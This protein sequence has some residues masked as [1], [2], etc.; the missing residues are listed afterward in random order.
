MNYE[1]SRVVF[2]VNS[3]PFQTQCVSQKN[4]IVHKKEF[5]MAAETVLKSTNMDDSM[6]SVP[7]KNQGIELCKS[8]VR[9]ME[10]SWNVCT[11]KAI[12]YISS[13]GEHYT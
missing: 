8:A 2:G 5:P 3:S 11:Q 12:Q 10:K 6:D 1:F 7:D 4:A 9:V 13:F